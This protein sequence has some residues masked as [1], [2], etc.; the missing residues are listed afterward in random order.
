MEER[1]YQYGNNIVSYGDLKS[2]F[3]AEVDSKI[4]ELN[5]SPIDELQDTTLPVDNVPREVIKITKNVSQKGEQ[6]EWFIHQ[7]K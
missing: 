2:Q 6:N 5:L 1:Y 7:I 3:G 4:S